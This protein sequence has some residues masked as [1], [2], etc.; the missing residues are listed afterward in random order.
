M[1][2]T[3]LMM[4]NS[5]IERYH[6]YHYARRAAITRIKKI[7]LVI[8]N[9]GLFSIAT[10]RF[11]CWI[12]ECFSSS[13]IKYIRYIFMVFFY[14]GKK[15]SIW[16]AKSE[17]YDAM[18]IG[19]GLYISNGGGV[20][21]GATSIG[22]NCTIASTV[23]M[24]MDLNGKTPRIGDNVVIGNNSVIYGDIN[25]GNGVVVSENSVVSKTMPENVL[26]KGNPARIVLKNIASNEYIHIATY[27]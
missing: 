3:N 11:G 20:I 24:G 25:I 19:P 27:K 10:Y 22:K 26:V 18:P 17:I 1:T 23:T 12:S 9:P 7:L 4:L 14:F 6:E 5:D 15:I 16:W 8:T 21:I 2:S 13:N